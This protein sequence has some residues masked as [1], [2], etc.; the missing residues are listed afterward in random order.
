MWC[1]QNSYMLVSYSAQTNPASSP[2]FTKPASQPLLWGCMDDHGCVTLRCERASKG[3]SSG[4]A[5]EGLIPSIPSICFA[6]CFFFFSVLKLCKMQWRTA[7]AAKPR[8]RSNHILWC[9]HYTALPLGDWPFC[10]SAVPM[11]ADLAPGSSLFW[12]TTIQQSP[13]TTC[14]RHTNTPC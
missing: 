4:E 10:H 2:Y 13:S 1:E 9:H 3:V 14:H 5:F 6:D 11:V 7:P 12:V 8:L